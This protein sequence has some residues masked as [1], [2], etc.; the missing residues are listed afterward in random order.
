LI[1]L[2]LLKDGLRIFGQR[3]RKG[4]RH[5][6]TAED[7]SKN[8][9]STCWNGEYFQ[10]SSGNFNEF[11]MRD[12]AYVI[13]SL[14]QLGYKKEVTQTLVYALQKYELHNSV[15]TT[16]THAGEAVN[17]FNL[18]PDSLALLLRSL[19]ILNNKSLIREYSKFLSCEIERYTS[20]IFDPVLGLVKKNRYFS[21]AKD[22]AVRSS[23]VYDNVMLA[24]IASEAKSLSLSNSFKGYNFK[25]NIFETFWRDSYFIDHFQSEIISGDANLYPYWTGLFSSKKMIL[26]SIETMEEIGLTKPFPLKYTTKEDAKKVR[27]LSPYK[28]LV[29][30]YEGDAIWA[31]HGMNYLSLLSQVDKNRMRT[32]LEQYKNLIEKHNSFV[33][34]YSPNGKPYKTLFYK[35]DKGMIWAATFLSLWNQYY[36]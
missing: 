24:I 30:N 17:V 6:G 3:F 15:T 5:I 26:K 31:H 9:L 14:L 29:P 32:H 35:A 27:F 1:S 20:G 7:I 2:P 10:V 23:S 19:R 4:H 28:Y 21:S 18:A 22:H 25:K 16:I 33:E 12:F 13:E 34:V 8:I 36:Q 11:Y